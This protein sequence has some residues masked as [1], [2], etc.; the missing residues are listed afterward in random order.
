MSAG[1]PVRVLRPLLVKAKINKINIIIIKNIN[2]HEVMIKISIKVKMIIDKKIKE[3]M[4]RQ[5]KVGQIG[6]ASCRERV[7]RSV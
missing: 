1:R 2:E 6:R 7:S 3:D 4:T 5:G